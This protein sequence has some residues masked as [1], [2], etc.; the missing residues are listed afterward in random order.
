MKIIFFGTPH[1]VVP[2]LSALHKEY[3]HGRDKNLVAVV[4]QPPRPVGRDKKIEY[5]AVDTFAHTHKIE[6]CHDTTDLPYAD[7]GVCAAY[8]EIIP[9]EVIKQF[10]YGILNIHP[11]LLPAYRGA[12]PI[13]SQIVAG[14]TKTGV[15]VIKMD[16]EMDHGPVVSVI[17]DEITPEDNQET[18]R[19][20][21]FEKTAEALLALI[22]PYIGGKVKLSPQDE[23]K[24]TFTKLIKREDGFV[25]GPIIEK[26][27]KGKNV[28]EPM[29]LRFIKD[30]EI[31]PTPEFIVHM[32]NGLSPWPG[33]YTEI[34][35]SEDGG[36]G[37][38][39]KILAAHCEEN[40]L[41][42]DQVQLE[43]RNPVAWKQFCEG[44][45]GFTY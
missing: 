4:T 27:L 24:A 37:K 22:P 18:L 28:D 29:T 34:K 41:V 11:S 6:I 38:R 5:S 7:L 9:D 1:F 2:I 3:N 40:A 33:I 8:G 39:L 14:E 10:Q 32:M 15:S 13:Q 12:S 44:Y 30:F 31:T 45:K 21:L 23:T 26:L 35:F 43:G 25:A 19:N 36:Y 42:L 16:A 20:R 17:R